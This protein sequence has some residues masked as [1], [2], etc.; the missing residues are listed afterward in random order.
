MAHLETITLRGTMQGPIY[1]P[2]GD[3][4][5]MS[6]DVAFNPPHAAYRSAFRQDWHSLDDALQ[7]VLGCGDFMGGMGD[8]QEGW[9]AFTMWDGARRI[10]VEKP[11]SAMAGARHYLAAEWGD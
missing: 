2:V 9:L 3:V 11:L 8:L 5:E 1:W 6:F 4:C 10:T 7:H